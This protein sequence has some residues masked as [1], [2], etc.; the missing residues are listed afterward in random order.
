MTQD[1]LVQIVIPLLGL[2]FGFIARQPSVQKYKKLVKGAGK[3]LDD[4]S[5]PNP[6]IQHDALSKGIPEIVEILDKYMK[7]QQKKQ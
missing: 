4:L 2:I 7:A 1:I 6:Q 5:D 3:Y